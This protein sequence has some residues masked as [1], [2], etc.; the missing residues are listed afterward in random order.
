MTDPYRGGSTDS[1]LECPRCG[2][3]LPPLEVATCMN[4]C[5]TW[6]T[7]EAAS[8]VFTPDE[9]AVNA[10]AKWWRIRAPCPT[11]GV[12]MKSRNRDDDAMFQGCDAHGVFVDADV[13][14]KTSLGRTDVR[15]LLAARRA[16][17]DRQRD[18]ERAR[19]AALERAEQLRRQEA[20]KERREEENRR[21]GERAQ[22]AAQKRAREE[23]IR[24]KREA[25][26]RQREAER[27]RHEAERRRQEDERARQEE[28]TRAM[29]ERE[30]A[31]REAVAE[32]RRREREEL[33]ALLAAK[34]PAVLER[35]NAALA[36]GDGS[37]LVDEIIELERTAGGLAKRL[38]RIERKLGLSE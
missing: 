38:E 8:Y 7:G 25:E 28:E 32:E 34:R 10:L 21:S 33:E 30:R 27:A 22:Q 26:Q 18:E 9:L 6:V 2:K 23:D 37:S 20:E 36:S 31:A 17:A 12:Q 24:L 16:G 3:G 14:H 29:L 5:G 19:E 13:M 4:D 15:E 35:V 11:C 1:G